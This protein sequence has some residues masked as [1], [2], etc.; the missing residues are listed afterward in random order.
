MDLTR[1][2]PKSLA[3]PLEIWTIREDDF[4]RG[5]S[6]LSETLFSL[7]NGYIG[8]RGTFE[9]GAGDPNS[10]CEG[11]YLNGVYMRE[12]IPYGENAA[13]FASHNHKMAPVPNGKSVRIFIGAE[14]FRPEKGTLH[15]HSQQL[16]MRR[17]L[18]TRHADWTSPSGKRLHLDSRRFVSLADSHLMALEISVTPLN[19][20]GVLDIHSGLDCSSG[21]VQ[22]NDD[23]RVGKLSLK[24][25]LTLVEKHT[26]NGHGFLR[27]N[28]IGGD[29][30][31]CSAFSESISGPGAPDSLTWSTPDG[32]GMR[33]ICPALQNQPVILTKYIAYFHKENSSKA[34]LPQMAGHCLTAAASNGFDVLLEQH[35]QVLDDFWR[36]A[37]ITID[38][39]PALQQGMRFNLFHIFLSAGRD[40]R[41]NISAKGLTGPGYDGHYFWDTEIYIIPSLLYSMP[42]IARKLLEYRYHILPAARTRA[43]QMGHGTGALYPWRTIGGEECSAFF[44]ASTAQYHIN[45]AIA[46]AIDHYYEVTEDWAFIGKY[47]AEMIF[48]TARLWPGLGHFSARHQGQFCLYEV[49]GPDE[50]TAMVDN[51][52]YTNAMAQRHLAIAVKIATEMAHLDPA[53]FRMLC[54]R[55][56]LSDDEIAL[57]AEMAEK[58]YLPYDKDLQINPQDDS[59]L[60]KPEWD[61]AN[62][63]KENYPLLLHYHPLVIYRHQVLKQADVILAM[64]LL[65]ER[66][67]IDLKRRNLDYYEPRTTHDSTL[68]SCIHSIICTEVGEASAAYDFFE[69]T[70]RMDL[71]NHHHNSEYGVHTAAMAGSWMA[72]VNGFAGMRL[73]HSRLSF[74]PTLPKAWT[75]YH[76]SLRF[77][78]RRITL[79]VT[80]DQVTYALTDGPE[81]MILHEDQ[82]V[83]LT[84]GAPVSRLLK[85]PGEK[86]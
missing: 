37:D 52:F 55:I 26:D 33:H 50:Y 20:D 69:D 79:S 22:D 2:T 83:S 28:T 17:G 77:R 35:C 47:G 12:K 34:S 80:T 60:D 66:Y 81:L 72:V 41:S 62:V 4:S 3:A 7:A 76:F 63:P 13:G 8:T 68:S 57:W 42:D 53:A 38:G 82:N 14:E 85:V 86:P 51:N 15:H 21:S 24:D 78:G 64:F 59:F 5:N 27:H 65:G 74:A 10:S 19:F 29:R 36:D 23:P 11:T 45:A 40:G 70:A 31:I 75:G 61:F 16:D 18:L 1:A 48:E 9:E 54:N 73:H 46:Y 25:S 58:M 30:E 67:S 84:K 43:R 39:D 71:D 44:P 56:D 49:T 32:I 6:M